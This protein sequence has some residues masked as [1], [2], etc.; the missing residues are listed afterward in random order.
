MPRL[1]P[2][3]ARALSVWMGATSCRR[4][5]AVLAGAGRARGARG[6]QHNRQPSHGS[7]IVIM[8][9][10][11]ERLA[12]LDEWIRSWLVPR[13]PA[14]ALTVLAG[15]TAPDS[16][17]RADPAWREL[18]RVVSLRNLSPADSRQYLR[19]CGVDPVRFDQL[20]DLAHGHPLGLSL[21]A[22]V[23][24]RG[25]EAAAD[26]LTPDLVGTL[27]RR[28]VEIVPSEQ[29]RH[30]LE[31][32]ALARVTTEALLREVFGAGGCTR[33]VRLAER[34]V[35]RGVGARRCVPARSGSRRTGH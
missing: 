22:D 30:A 28:F 5:Q 6:G 17:W 10:T 4:H 35:F 23:D 8:F 18:L 26:P 16:A 12:S 2:R 25:G 31:V 1:R 3:S 27:L 9:D 24:V 14:D 32:C 29:H 7:R 34:A 15:R 19:A 21:L 20:V 33:R 11:Y 13:L